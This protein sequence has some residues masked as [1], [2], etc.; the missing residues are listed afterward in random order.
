MGFRRFVFSA[1]LYGAYG[2]AQLLATGDDILHP[3][4]FQLGPADGVQGDG[5]CAAAAHGDRPGQFL[6]PFIGNGAEDDAV[7]LFIRKGHGRSAAAANG[8]GHHLQFREGAAHA[9]RVHQ[10]QPQPCAGSDG[11]HGIYPACLDGQKGIDLFSEKLG[12]HLMQGLIF[13]AADPL[14]RQYGR[15]PHHGDGHD[16]GVIRQLHGVQ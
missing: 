12:Y 9:V 11:E 5:Y 3:V 8:K 15:R 2:L 7:P 14:F 13:L 4:L 1:I 6:G 16:Q 10:G